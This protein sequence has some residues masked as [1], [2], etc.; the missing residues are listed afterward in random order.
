MSSDNL[1]RVFVNI[2]VAERSEDFRCAASWNIC[3]DLFFIGFILSCQNGARS[4]GQCG[5]G[6]ADCGGGAGE[7]VLPGNP[8]LVCGRCTENAQHHCLSLYRASR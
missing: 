4:C 7:R 5:T 8:Y 2:A 3:V 1:D 6:R